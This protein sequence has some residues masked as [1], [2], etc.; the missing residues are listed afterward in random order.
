M[1][2]QTKHHLSVHLFYRNK[3]GEETTS[4]KIATNLNKAID[5]YKRINYNFKH[6]QTEAN[7]GDKNGKP[8]DKN[9]DD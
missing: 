8:T 3:R 1:V 2:S 4:K 6:E 7:R 5:N 9:E